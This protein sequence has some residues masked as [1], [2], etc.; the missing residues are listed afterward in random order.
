MSN[1]H[2]ERLAKEYHKNFICWG[3]PN[4]EEVGVQYKEASLYEGSVRFLIDVAN[5]LIHTH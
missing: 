1:F 5:K 4:Y 3:F 2:G